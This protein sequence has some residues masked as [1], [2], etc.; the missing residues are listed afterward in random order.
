MFDGK[1][2]LITGGTGS[3]GFALTKEILKTEVDTL[4][5]YSRNESKQI[6]MQSKV[7]DPRL[8]FLI[9]DIRDKERLSKALEDIDIVIHA[10]ALKHVPIV[11]YNPFEAIKT[12]VLGSQNVIECCLQEDVEIAICIGTDKAV[13]PL[14]TYGATKHLMEDLF[15]TAS[16]YTNP[17]RHRTKFIAVRYGNVLA[18][19]NSVVPKFIEQIKNG[20]ELT[21]TDFSMTRFNITMNQAMKLIFDSIKLGK[22]G[23]IF[24]PKLKSY[25]LETLKDSLFDV[26]KKSINIK[27]ISVRPGEK[28][29]ESLISEEELRNTYEINDYY[30]IVDKQMNQNTFSKWDCLEET[31]RTEQYSSDKVELLTKDELIEILINEKL[32]R[33]D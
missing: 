3:L 25:K 16:N 7:D 17:K 32:V 15:T 29:H 31:K 14:N 18:S 8:R 11:E 13:S 5:I 26:F 20:G 19:S 33:N 4:R 22:G 28:F 9:G 21:I 24:I 6:E 23:E 30:I 1:K 27:K 10:A 2:V 12:N